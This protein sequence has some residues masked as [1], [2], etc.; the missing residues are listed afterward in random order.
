MRLYKGSKFAFYRRTSKN[1]RKL[2]S[3]AVSLKPGDV[4]GAC[5]GFNHIV[6]TINPIWGRH[7]DYN[8]VGKGGHKTYY[9][10]EVE[11]EAIDGSF[12]VCPGGGCAH[13]PYSVKEIHEYWN[14]MSDKFLNEWDES[15]YWKKI[16]EAARAGKPITD[17][18]GIMLPEF[19][20]RY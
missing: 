6:K 15:G 1:T 8:F 7:S 2:L 18:K 12:H 14:S 16:V 19:M 9:V 13:Q 17:D 10:V 5:S 20:R 11:I 4:F 3:W